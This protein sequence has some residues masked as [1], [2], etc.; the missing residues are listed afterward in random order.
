MQSLRSPRRL[1]APVAAVRRTVRVCAQASATTRLART[2]AT[3]KC[4]APDKSDKR[5]RLGR[6]EILATTVP[7][8]SLA[9]IT[10]E[11]LLFLVLVACILMA[12]LL[13]V[14]GQ[15]TF[16]TG[17]SDLFREVRSGLS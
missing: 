5:Q 9:W 7:A 12:L 2:K 4:G 10:S 14:Q 16:V 13:Q 15:S 1:L 3:V 11:L 8:D 17:W 6:S